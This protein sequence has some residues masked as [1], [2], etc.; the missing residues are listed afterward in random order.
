LPAP[1]DDQYS[2]PDV[3]A[4]GQQSDDQAV[5]RRRRRRP[6]GN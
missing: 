1:F 3:P 2:V 5:F 4:P 6:N